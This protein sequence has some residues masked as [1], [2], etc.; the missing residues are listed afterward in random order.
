MTSAAEPAAVDR[1]DIRTIV[2]GGAQL[3]GITVVGV[4]VF[5]LL[6]R[7]MVGAVE[8]VVQT[9]LVTAGVA[10]F[11]YFPAR[12]VR[13]TGVDG[14]GWTAMLGLMGSLFF[15]VVDTALLRPFKLYHWTWDQIGGGSGFWYVPVWWMGSAT[16]AWLGGWVWARAAGQGMGARAGQTVGFGLV[17]LAIIVFTGILPFHAGTAALAVT[18]GLVATVPV[19]GPARG[20]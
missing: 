1:S 8:T 15:T 10:V 18:L 2:G 7:M 9:A 16:L 19:A 17:L 12:R 13:P 6:S 4:V 5:A 3:G 20:A 14:I 11:A